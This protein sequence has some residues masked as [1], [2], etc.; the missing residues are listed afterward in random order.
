M[1]RSRGRELV[2]GLCPHQ[3]TRPSVLPPSG[4][5]FI[6][7]GQASWTLQGL[8]WPRHWWPLL[9]GAWAH[10]KA[11]PELSVLPPWGRRGG[12]WAAA[13]SIPNRRLGGCSPGGWVLGLGLGPAAAQG[14]P[15]GRQGGEEAAL[16]AL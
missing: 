16:P 5:G 10:G 8:G 15:W 3:G 6:V 9:A 13:S 11:I 2:S 4:G 14:A 12:P 1:T 7:G